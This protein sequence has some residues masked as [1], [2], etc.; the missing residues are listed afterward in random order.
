MI[1]W[2]LREVVGYI[3]GKRNEFLKESNAKQNNKTE[4]AISA[5]HKTSDLMMC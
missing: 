2:Y 4:M 5:C 1:V 3:E